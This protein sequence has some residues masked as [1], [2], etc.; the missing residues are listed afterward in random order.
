[1]SILEGVLP[2][3]VEGCREHIVARN[4]RRLLDVL[5]RR[6][7]ICV[8]GTVVEERDVPEVTSLVVRG[9]RRGSFIGL[10]HLPVAS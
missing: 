4:W 8:R 5:V 10:E 6:R 2:S 9:W 7:E 1:V 3:S